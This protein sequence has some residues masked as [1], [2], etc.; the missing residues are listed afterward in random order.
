MTFHTTF[1][2]TFRVFATA[3][4]FT[5]LVATLA[6]L[7]IQAQ[8]LTPLQAQTLSPPKVGSDRPQ[9]ADFIVAIVNSEPI[10]NGE[11]RLETSRLAQQLSQ[12]RRP[13]PSARE[14][15][16]V[17]LERMISDKAQVQL[18]R[19]QGLRVDEAMVEIVWDPPWHQSMITADGRK[20]LGL[21]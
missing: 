4:L 18:A 13:V 1:R 11:L 2:A 12:A 3:T 7:G 10:T 15:T 14:L 21:G 16:R 5:T 8:G 9:Q 19:E 6:P 17:V 20:I